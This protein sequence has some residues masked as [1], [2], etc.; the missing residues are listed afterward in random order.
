ML[1]STWL[2]LF[3]VSC[4]A[5]MLGLNISAA[6]N[7]AITIYILI[8]ILLIPQMIFSGAMFN[9]DKLNDWIGSED[10]VPLVA[11]FMASRWAFEALAVD[12]FKSNK[13]EKQ[14]YSYEKF[15]SIA[16][17]KRV[18]YL[19]EL[20]QANQYCI[21]YIGVQDA[22]AIKRVKKHLK[23]LNEQYTSLF[24]V[25][26]SDI[27]PLKYDSITKADLWKLER[28]IVNRYDLD[29]ARI[30]T[31]KSTIDSC[32]RYIRYDLKDRRYHLSKKLSY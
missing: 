8:P 21:R 24:S 27:N 3:T 14:F 13:F 9:F 32:K 5:N 7:S 2:C 25:Q 28:L 15:E 10:K 1:L 6:F 30:A 20:Q 23:S 18:Y 31:Y 26:H 4:F 19:P 29:S 16:D 12:E 17:F 22:S 11:D